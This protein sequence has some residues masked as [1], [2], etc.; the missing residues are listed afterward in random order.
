MN[1]IDLVICTRNRQETLVELLAGL[2]NCDDMKDVELYI[3]DNSDLQISTQMSLESKVLEFEKFFKNT[4]YFTCSPGLVNAR[5]KALIETKSDLIIFIDDDVKVPKDFI[6]KIRSV[7]LDVEISGA[8][9]LIKG[10]YEG[11]S[12]K[13]FI[14]R[15]CFSNLFGRVLLTS[16]TFWVPVGIQFKRPVDW[17]PGCCMAYRKKHIEGLIFS[18]ELQSGSSGGYSLGEDVDFSLSAGQRGELVCISDLIIEHDMSSEN[19]VTDLT[20]NRAIGEWRSYAS[21]KYQGTSYG[22]TLLFEIIYFITA[23][24]TR[25][26][27]VKISFARWSGFRSNPMNIRRHG[28]E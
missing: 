17:L 22:A 10:L 21:R 16:H 1:S 18:E 12:I 15:N 4:F 28:N 23:C 19:R 11:D 14:F 3:I 20:L 8:A 9:P 7:F 27:H 13:N 24:L 2:S 6:Q 26:K 25:P 5:N